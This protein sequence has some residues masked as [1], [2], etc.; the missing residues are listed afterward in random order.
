MIN[1]FKIAFIGLFKAF[2]DKSVLLQL[3]IGLM[4]ILFSCLIK[5]DKIDFI[6]ILFCIALVI[7]TEMLNT[8]IEKI[9]DIYT[10][11][12]DDKIKNIKDIG[13][14]A[15]LLASIVSLIIGICI[16]IPYF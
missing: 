12:Y 7:I 11:E 10:N 5:I 16:F 4:V 9:C 2:K 1:K 14:G 15:V 13:A 3:I 8:C 6:L